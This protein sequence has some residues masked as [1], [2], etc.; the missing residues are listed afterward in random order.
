MP[1]R[2]LSHLRAGRSSRLERSSDQLHVPAQTGGLSGPEH[3]GGHLLSDRS[4]KG[5][6]I[7]PELRWYLETSDTRDAPRGFHLGGYARVSNISF[8]A[9]LSATGTGTDASG[10]VQGLLAVDFF[11]FGIGIQAGYQLLMI[12]TGS[13]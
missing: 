5:W 12:G 1:C 10:S 6:F 13:P 9:S 8:D 3:R 11:E 2:T 7:T 4:L